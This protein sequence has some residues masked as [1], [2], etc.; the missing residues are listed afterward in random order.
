M[1][2]ASSAT[3]D[4]RATTVTA[5][6]HDGHDREEKLAVAALGGD[7]HRHL[8]CRPES[9]PSVS[10]ARLCHGQC[11]AMNRPRWAPSYGMT[12]SG[13]R[14]GRRAEKLADLPSVD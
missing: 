9:A 8:L 11:R 3:L 7:T 6:Q 13:G 1:H 10:D 12:R 4:T 14:C 5:P 2:E